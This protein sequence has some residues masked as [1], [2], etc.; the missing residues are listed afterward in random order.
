MTRDPVLRRAVII[1]FA[2]ALMVWGILF[3][4]ERMFEM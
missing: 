2:V 1:A 3:S 4:N